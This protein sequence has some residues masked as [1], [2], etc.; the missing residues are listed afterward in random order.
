MSIRLTVR[1]VYD[2]G[3]DR[4]L[5]GEDLVRPDAWDALRLGSDGPFGLAADRQQWEAQARV[6]VDLEQRAQALVRWIAAA[7]GRSVASYGIGTGLLEHHLHRLDPALALTVTDYAPQTVE[8]LRSLFDESVEV[9]RHDLLA[10]DPLEADLHLMHRV[11]SELS[12]QQWRELLHRFRAAR[13]LIVGTE[14]ASLRRVLLELLFRARRP[15]ATR[16]GWLRTRGAFD[17]LW[18]QTHDPHPMQ[19]GDLSAWDLRPR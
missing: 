6:A 5:V 16:A 2:F 1:H 9:R 12:D 10:D 3:T 18:L 11:D 4:S 13:V 17:A 8:R 15:R 14:V 19:V 7:G